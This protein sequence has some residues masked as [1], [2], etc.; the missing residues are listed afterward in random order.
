MTDKSTEEWKLHIRS[1]IIQNMRYSIDG[2]SHNDLPDH[3]FNF[4]VQGLKNSLVFLENE[5]GENAE[6]DSQIP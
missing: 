3:I 5:R 4:M 1:I 2:L 6:K